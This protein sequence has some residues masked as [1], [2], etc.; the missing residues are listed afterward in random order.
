VI[1]VKTYLRTFLLFALA[2]LS[3]PT[4]ASAETLYACKWNSIGT[5]RMV[6]A[7]A[8]CSQF[9][10]KISWSSTG[11]Q[12]PQG[13]PGPQ[14]SPGAP[15]SQGVQ[16]P[17]GQQGLPGMPGAI[18]PPGPVGPAGEKGLPGDKG[19][20][21]LQ[22]PKGDKGDPGAPGGGALSCTAPTNYLVNIG[23]A[24]VCQPRNVDNGDGTVTDNKTGLMWEK[25]TG[26][27]GTP[28]PIDVHDVNNTYAWSASNS[29]ANG[30]LYT[31]F[32]PTL[33]LNSTTFAL[34][35]V[36][37]ANHCDWRIPT[38][39]ELQSILDFSVPGCGSVSPCIDPTLGPTQ[40][41]T[42]YWSSSVLAAPSG[43]ALLFS[44]ADGSPFNGLVDPYY[45]RAVRGGR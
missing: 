36:C 40:N 21:G 38:I 29:A 39:I 16:G 13:V 14:G 7:T 33:N 45:A 23:T 44:F 20:A 18:G 34:T 35:S 11:S 43:G 3:A 32:L 27:V 24:F 1:D 42:Y 26:T 2:Y 12:G 17:P 22:G 19:D 15:G 25:K 8:N 9:E 6:S 5:I 41:E 4:M 28:N 31:S 10:T 37:F 30:T